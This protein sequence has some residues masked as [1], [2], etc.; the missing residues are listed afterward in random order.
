MRQVWPQGNRRSEG[1]TIVKLLTVV[2][3]KR[4]RHSGFFHA[5]EGYEGFAFAYAGEKGERG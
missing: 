3:Q 1:L 5:C 4:L 2:C